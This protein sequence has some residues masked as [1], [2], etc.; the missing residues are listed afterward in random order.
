MID[1]GGSAIA[2][3]EAGQ[4]PVL[5]FYTGIGSFIWRDV[6]VR[7]SSD[8]RCITLDPPGIGHSDP[9]PRVDTTL[10]TSSC[11]LS[12][13]IGAL[14]LTDITLG[15]RFRRATRVRRGSARAGSLSRPRRCEHVRVAAGGYSVP[16]NTRSHG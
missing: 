2:V 8:F 10:R 5:L 13:V 6:M 9:V 3:S 1:A 12:G 11:T 16:R 7:L 15:A 4:R 14:G